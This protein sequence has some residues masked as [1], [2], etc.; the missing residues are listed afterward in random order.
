MLMLAA[1]VAGAWWGAFYAWRKD[2]F[3]L[4]VSHAVWSAVVFAVL[5]IR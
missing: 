4:I 5:P 1:F 2:L 3:T